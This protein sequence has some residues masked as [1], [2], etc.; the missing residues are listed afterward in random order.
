MKDA[1]SGQMAHPTVFIDGAKGDGMMGRGRGKDRRTVVPAC[2]E[3]LHRR[4]YMLQV[5]D[6]S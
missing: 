6:W 4:S 2:A 1:N 5:V 3:L